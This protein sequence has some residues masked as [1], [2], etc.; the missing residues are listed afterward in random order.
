MEQYFRLYTWQ[1]PDFDITKGKRDPSK[2]A[3]SWG[4]KWDV[5]QQP[6]LELYKRVGTSDFAW[7]YPEYTHWMQSDIRR[8]W[9]LD[10]PC[11]KIFRVL[12]NKIWTEMIRDAEDNEQPKETSWDKLFVERSEEID[13]ISA[14]NND[15]II[16]LVPIPLCA[17]I[18]I[19][20]KSRFNKGP[21]DPN[22]KYTDLPISECEARRCRD[23]GYKRR[24]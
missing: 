14:G 7:C 6:C 4:D 1:N 3:Q 16:P 13:I 8:L 9:V 22:A 11:Q 23:E 21:K 18:Q 20:N 2:G 17:S 10:V 12:D 15:D 24:T 19:I 5:L